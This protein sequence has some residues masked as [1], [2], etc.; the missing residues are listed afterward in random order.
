MENKLTVI[1]F[2]EAIKKNQIDGWVTAGIGRLHTYLHPLKCYIG[3]TC[4]LNEWQTN[5]YFRKL[6]Q[7][8]SI[9]Y[10]KPN[11]RFRVA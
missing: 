5:Y 1:A 4:G 7:E 11:Q 6:V 9:E 2:L 10:D 8:G 3:K